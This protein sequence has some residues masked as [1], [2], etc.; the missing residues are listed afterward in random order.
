MSS[1][2]SAFH[3]EWG[4]NKGTHP[5]GSR[6]QPL[7]LI[8]CPCSERASRTLSGGVA[9]FLQGRQRANR[10]VFRPRAAQEY[11]EWTESCTSWW[12]VHGE[13]PVPSGAG[14]CS[15]TVEPSNVLQADCTLNTSH[16]RNT[17]DNW[18]L[19]MG[20]CAKTENGGKATLKQIH[21][22]MAT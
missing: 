1:E 17:L 8:P 14:F 3:P 4:P 9:P 10:A 13:S 18:Q 6:I 16:S 22:Q 2:V 19:E 21:T 11:R 5:R 12:V 20:T 7:M 15:S